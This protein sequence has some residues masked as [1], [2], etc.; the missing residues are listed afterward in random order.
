MLASN[1]VYQIKNTFIKTMMKSTWYDLVFHFLC[2]IPGPIFM[3]DP[4]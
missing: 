1:P 3:A 4:A 2:T